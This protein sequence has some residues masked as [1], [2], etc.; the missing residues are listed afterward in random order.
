M[1]CNFKKRAAYLLCAGVV[2]AGTVLPASHRAKATHFPAGS[3]CTAVAPAIPDLN[4]DQAIQLIPLRMNQRKAQNR[5]GQGQQGGETV[6][7]PDEREESISSDAPTA[8]I[9]EPSSEPP[10]SLDEYLSL[11]FCGGCRKNCSLMAPRC[12]TGF[13]MQETATEEYHAMYAAEEPEASSDAA[14]TPAPTTPPSSAPRITAAP[15]PRASSEPD[16]TIQE[17]PEVPEDEIREHLG[18]LFCTGCANR[19]PLSAPLCLIGEDKAATEKAQY[20]DTYPETSRG[21]QPQAEQQSK[22]EPVRQDDRSY[23]SI[24]NQSAEVLP[25]AGLAFGSV[26]LVKSRFKRKGRD[27]NE[28]EK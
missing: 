21:E 3:V 18:G 20:I 19:C 14:P 26:L 10:P 13:S 2:A 23:L 9:T 22:T 1:I 12:A 24:L 6:A 25:Y 17:N 28:D 7:A 4:M 15:D 11:L 8:K 5:N 16:T 27:T